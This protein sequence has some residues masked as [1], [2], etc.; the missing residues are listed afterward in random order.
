MRTLPEGESWG[1]ATRIDR[2]PYAA[3][4][5]EESINLC[6]EKRNNIEGLN[7]YYLPMLQRQQESRRVTLD[8]RLTTAEIATLFTADGRKPSLRTLFRINIQGESLPFRLAKIEH[9]NAE[10][11]IVRCTFE[12]ELNN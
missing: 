12:Q 7:R 1:I 10:S 8:I 2:Y 3:F 5:D 4:V 6:F 11:N 9:W